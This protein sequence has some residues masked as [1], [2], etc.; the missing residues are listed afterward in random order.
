MDNQSILNIGVPILVSVVAILAIGYG[1]TVYDDI[2]TKPKP[3]YPSI[4]TN[5]L[6]DL[7]EAKK[8]LSEL[9]NEVFPA[10]TEKMNK[11]IEKIDKISNSLKN[12]SPGKS[13][14]SSVARGNKSKKKDKNKRK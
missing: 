6:E 3:K 13:R 10:I 8:N 9:H 11:E 5:D 7:K 1:K 4:S 14:A 12:R 2:N